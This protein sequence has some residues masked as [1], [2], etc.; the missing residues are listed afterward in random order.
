[1]GNQVTVHTPRHRIF[2]HEDDTLG[3]AGSEEWQAFVEDPDGHLVGLIEFVR[4]EVRTPDR[5]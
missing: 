3:P 1:M 4:G 2:R 5:P